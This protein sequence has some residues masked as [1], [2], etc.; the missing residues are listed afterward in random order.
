MTS[1]ND[2]LIRRAVATEIGFAGS[3]GITGASI[4]DSLVA[5]AGQ[6]G[7]AKGKIKHWIR[8]LEVQSAIRRHA[9][10]DSP[11]VAAP[12]KWAEARWVTRF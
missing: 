10:D 6:T 4:I 2:N 9:D 1:Q 8:Y 12:L 5:V 3:S 7:W 11:E